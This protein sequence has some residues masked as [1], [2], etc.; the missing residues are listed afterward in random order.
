MSPLRHAPTLVSLAVVVFAF[1]CKEGGSS[2][3]GAPSAASAAAKP[4]T[5]RLPN[6]QCP[7]PG[8]TCASGE[9]ERYTGC[10]DAK[11]DTENK[12]CF[13]PNY[14]KAAF[15]GPCKDHMAC[16]AACAC[17]DTPCM[18]KCAPS[19]ECR[20]CLTSTV[21][22]CVRGAGCEVPACAAP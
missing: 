3:G 7:P 22:A 11:C 19:A 6:G 16:V 12:L 1:A 10:V 17:D 15:G 4:A 13:G 18:Q 14:Q 8:S 9:Y 21:L 2:S 5:K 20:A